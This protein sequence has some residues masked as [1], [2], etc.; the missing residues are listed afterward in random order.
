MALVQID[1]T[2]DRRKLREFGLIGM[3]AFTLFAALTFFDVWF[4]AALP[5]AAVYVL[6]SLAIANGL[7]ALLSPPALRPEYIVLSVAAYPI[8][9][10][11]SHVMMAI[12]FYG[13]IT[14]VGL[15]F[16]LIGRDALARRFEPDADTYWVRRRPPESVKRYFRQF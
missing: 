14:P 2:P 7:L 13:V 9:F 16:K 3:C 5:S 10:V 6:S 8:G 4:F 12:I 11:V 1:W 15:L